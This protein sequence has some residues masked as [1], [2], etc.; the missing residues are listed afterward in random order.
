MKAHEGQR[1]YL[2]YS[3]RAACLSCGSRC[4]R[5]EGIL[6]K[7]KNQGRAEIHEHTKQSVHLLFRRRESWRLLHRRAPATLARRSLG[8]NCVLLLSLLKEDYQQDSR[9]VCSQKEGYGRHLVDIKLADSSSLEGEDGRG[10]EDCTSAEDGRGGG[11][12]MSTV[13][14]PWSCPR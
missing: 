4:E 9:R 13:S 14:S 3:V 12:G 5:C 7:P 8:V 6:P 11:C 10:A 2:R 1:W